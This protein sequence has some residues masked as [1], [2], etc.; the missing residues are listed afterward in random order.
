MKWEPIET[1]P[2]DGRKIIL[3]CDRF[4]LSIGSWRVDWGHSGDESPLWLRDDYDDFSCGYASTPLDPTHWM[5][6][7]E[8]PDEPRYYITEA[9][10]S[11]LHRDDGA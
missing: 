6:I 11:M 10:R 7:P 9:G 8:G 2:K 1:A 4:G 3:W 5:P